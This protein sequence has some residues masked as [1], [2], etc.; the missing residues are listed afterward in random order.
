MNNT[1]KKTVLQTENSSTYG[2]SILAEVK[3][4]NV[5]YTGES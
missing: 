2:D 5:N 1:Q 4:T 3:R